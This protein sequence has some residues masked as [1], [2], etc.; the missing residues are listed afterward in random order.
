MIAEGNRGTSTAETQEFAFP[1]FF[2]LLIF[3]VEIHLF[4]HPEFMDIGLKE[5]ADYA[6]KTS[7]CHD[8]SVWQDGEMTVAA[9][10][11]IVNGVRITICRNLEKSLLIEPQSP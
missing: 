5:V 4:A 6:I 7:A 1:T 3:P 9:M 2:K 11:S 10:T 8:F